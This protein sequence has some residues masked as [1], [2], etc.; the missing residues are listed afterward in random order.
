MCRC[1]R[2]KNPC[3]TRS[4]DDEF[5]GPDCFVG[6]SVVGLTRLRF[7]L[8]QELTTAAFALV[9]RTSRVSSQHPVSEGAKL[10][11]AAAVRD[12]HGRTYN[13]HRK[14]TS[15]APAGTERG[16][17]VRALHCSAA[18]KACRRSD[19]SARH[20]LLLASLPIRAALEGPAQRARLSFV[21][22]LR[23]RAHG[24]AESASS[25][26]TFWRGAIGGF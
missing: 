24:A 22:R 8:A 9:V 4:D 17:L 11:P 10:H 1:L 15:R 14:R 23:F 16:T 20:C 6:T 2:A 5:G 7:G 18:R 21:S 26:A 25:P 13:Y 3:I 12:R 19:Q